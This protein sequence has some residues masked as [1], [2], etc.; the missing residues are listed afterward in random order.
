VK[1]NGI[2]INADKQD[3]VFSKYLRVQNVIEGSGVGLYLV[4]EIVKS[5]GGK[6]V[7]KS[8]LGTGSEFKVY[9]KIKEM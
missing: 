8:E 4:N 2:G 5:S 7:L 9:L 1:D 3:A 6:V